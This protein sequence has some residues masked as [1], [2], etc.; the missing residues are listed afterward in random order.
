MECR[1]ERETDNGQIELKRKKK[2]VEEKEERQITMKER[3]EKRE[4]KKE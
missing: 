1:R 3:G 2:S 4:R